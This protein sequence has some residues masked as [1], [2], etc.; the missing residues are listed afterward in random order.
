MST[1]KACSKC[2]VEKY[3]SE[4]YRKK[5]T[6][7]G[8]RP[9]CKVCTN[10][11]NTRYRKENEEICRQRSAKYR[12]LNRD[13]IRAKDKQYRDTN[14]NQC[15]QRVLA[16]R[17][18]NYAKHISYRRKYYSENKDAIAARNSDWESRHPESRVIR[19]QRRRAR[20]LKLPHSFT[21][22][23]W[24]ECLEFFGN[25]CAY[26]G[27]SQESLHQDH[28]IP[29]SKGGPYTASNI[30]PACEHCNLSKSNVDMP[31]WYKHSGVF[32]E[33]RYEKVTSYLASK[34]GGGYY[35]FCERHMA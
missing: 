21:A 10:S 23:E 26:C 12:E 3:I 1:A 6:K 19:E 16:W 25:S 4:F 29:L 2:G 8:Y 7:D 30:V 33:E 35:G 20:K 11:A 27:E 17:E 31:F 22:R 34:D 14:K 24:K 18:N 5:S 15:T 9:E 32:C 13:I 28:V